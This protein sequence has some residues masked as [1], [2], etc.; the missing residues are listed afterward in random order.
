[1]AWRRRS[2]RGWSAGGEEQEIEVNRVLDYI[3]TS[4]EMEDTRK[5]HRA[6][7]ELRVGG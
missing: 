2:S 3:V 7:E 5:P 6:D 4:I 1:M